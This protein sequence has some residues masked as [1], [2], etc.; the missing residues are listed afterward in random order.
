MTG[1]DICS[2]CNK[3]E[4]LTS[5]QRGFKDG[6]L[7]LSLSTKPYYSGKTKQNKTKQ[8]QL[9]FLNNISSTPF[10]P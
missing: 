5:D 3:S 4:F 10:F 9:Y 7:S 6:V 8:K 2:Y 1:L